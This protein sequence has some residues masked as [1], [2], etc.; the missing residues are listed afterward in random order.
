MKYFILSIFVL[1]SLK[2]I[3][4]SNL[5]YNHFFKFKFNYSFSIDNQE[6][7]EL[8]AEDYLIK[9]HAL[10]FEYNQS[11]INF[12]KDR[13]TLSLSIFYDGSSYKSTN[14]STSFF[15]FFSTFDLMYHFKYKK[16]IISPFCGLGNTFSMLKLFHNP[17][18]QPLLLNNVFQLNNVKY[19]TFFQNSN[20]LLSS[21]IEF[22]YMINEKSSI[23]L[24]SRYKFKFGNEEVY[25]FNSKS[26][27]TDFPPFDIYHFTIGMG[28]T[29]YTNRWN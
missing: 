6:I 14:F 1:F 3:A 28:Y 23:G 19:L 27:V 15:S 21:G 2:G 4:Q 9:E 26:V 7:N 5:N 20:F 17:N 22:E 10:G 25:L 24:F 12:C 29:F 8:L 18:N 13:Y 11:V 16:V